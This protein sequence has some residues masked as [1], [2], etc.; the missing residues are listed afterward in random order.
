MFECEKEAV[1]SKLPEKHRASFG[2]MGYHKE[3]TVLV[4]SPYSVPPGKLRTMWLAKFA[5][6]RV[7]ITG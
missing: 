4:V 7:H 6:V 1:L 3:H 2:A 5:E